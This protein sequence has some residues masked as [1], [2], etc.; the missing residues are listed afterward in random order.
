M[1][2]FLPLFEKEQKIIFDLGN[3]I[4]DVY[5]ASFNVTITA[6][7]FTASDSITPADLILPISSRRSAVNMP[8]VY[9]VP[10]DTASNSLTLPQ[11]VKK[12]VFTIS[13]TGQSEEESETA[14]F[15]TYGTLYGFSPFR[16]VQLF[17][18]GQL[19][20]VAWPFPVIFTGG[21]VPGL[22]RPLVGID[23]F[24]LKEDEI[25]IT[26]WLP[27]L[28][29]GKAHDF[30]I[31]VSGLNDT[32]NGSATLSEITDNYWLV[33]GK[34]F[35]W[36]DT[37]GHI[38]TGTVPARLTPSPSVSVS[39]SISKSPD[40]TNDT[41]LYSVTAQRSLSVQSVLQ[42]SSGPHLATWHQALTYSN[43]GNFS[44]QGNIEINDQ[45]TNGYDVSSS[46][47]AKRYS[48]PLYV[49][50]VSAAYKD[51]ISYVA[52]V[53]RGKDVKTIGE[54]VFPTGLEAL[55]KA[56]SLQVLPPY[57]WGAHLATTQNGSATYLA[58]TTSSTSYSYGDTEQVFDFSGIQVS[59]TAG[60]HGFPSI[61]S[62]HELFHRYVQAVN[63]TVSTD[64][65]T[66][67]EESTHHGRPQPGNV[68]F[69]SPHVDSE[70]AA[71]SVISMIVQEGSG[72]TPYDVDPV[73]Q[74]L[75][76]RTAAIPLTDPRSPQR[77]ALDIPLLIYTCTTT[78]TVS[79][80]REQ[81]RRAALHISQGRSILSSQPNLST[82]M[83][84]VPSDLLRFPPALHT[85]QGRTIRS[86]RDAKMGEAAW[87]CVAGSV[88]APGRR[89]FDHSQGYLY[90]A[91]Y[92][93][94]EAIARMHRAKHLE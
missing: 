11:N 54:P 76:H 59:S 25:D 13:A 93:F 33:T 68:C 88:T 23:A 16:E 43:A 74:G 84:P 57:F 56:N 69:F 47:Y 12:A 14:T 30:T 15:P 94:V 55:T 32:G 67:V 9:T 91:T 83:T 66:L 78:G 20:G 62:S 2:N 86:P 71:F 92:W 34:V 45:H 49:Y 82:R 90:R 26:P 24:D 70:Y 1:T 79:L 89:Q 22:W 8:S 46:G 60:A 19:A 64:E 5:T 63:G 50:S 37:P 38:T 40:G 87:G 85:G 18:D 73:R 77:Q 61:S 52:N 65:E 28:C 58:N 10:P 29:D 21:I 41:L 17:I 51:N 4:S 44:D 7:F 31:R 27:I 75:Q 35:L 48:Y 3:L 80:A 42:L 36:L 81:F 39:S 72:S 6:A 53:N